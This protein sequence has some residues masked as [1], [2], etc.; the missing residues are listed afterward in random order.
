MTTNPDLNQEIHEEGVH[1]TS[2]SVLTAMAARLHL[3]ADE[4]AEVASEILEVHEPSASDL[5]HVKKHRELERKAF[6]R[7]AAYVLKG[8]D[9]MVGWGCVM[10]IFGHHSAI[11]GVQGPGELAKYLEAKVLTPVIED[12]RIVLRPGHRK[13]SKQMVNKCLQYFQGVLEEMPKINGQRSRQACENMTVARI[14][15]LTK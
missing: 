5:S 11:G 12:G 15:Q 13:F 6:V 3:T 9:W 7:L 4:M 10:L 14:E 1:K 8:G 2:E